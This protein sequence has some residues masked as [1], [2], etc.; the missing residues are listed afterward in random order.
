[1]K[2]LDRSDPNTFDAVIL[3][4][5]AA[6]LFCAGVSASRGLKVLVI[7]HCE[8]IAEKIRISGGGRCNFTNKNMDPQTP[9]KYFLG[10]NPQFCRS[11][12][13]K[14]TPDDFIELLNRYNVPF[15]EKHKGQLFCD[16]SAQN[17]IDVLISEAT[18]NKI[19]STEIR[20]PCKVIR[21]EHIKNAEPGFTDSNPNAFYSIT[22]D[23]SHVRCRS[24]VVATGGLSIPQ[25]GASDFGYSI[26]KQFNLSLVPTRPALV[27]LTF[28]GDTWAPYAHLSGLSL[29]VIIGTGQKKSR[30]EFAEDLL[31]THRGLSGPGVLQ[32]SSYWNPGDPVDV[33]LNPE[34]DL[35]DLFLQTK[36]TSR[37]LLVNEVST[38][39]PNRLA[40]AWIDQKTT[41]A[42]PINQISD[43]A[44]T[45]L[46]QN[47]Q[48]WEIQ[49][50]GTEGYKKAEV[51]AGGVNTKELSQQTME[52][53]QRGLYFIGEVV[54]ITGWLGGY[55]F[56][57]AWSSGF[58]CGQS[59]PQIE[60]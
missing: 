32:I 38:V 33:N 9:H 17:I 59:L 46:A 1:M 4:G 18:V 45:E 23:Q 16:R 29:P 44:L 43:Q 60:S 31:F 15:H 39:L 14:Y 47:L 26:A 24:L 3:G 37:R 19:G 7:D 27:P 5:G 54:D 42:N 56:Q 36:K 48:R 11:A 50:A 2:T 35:K 30:I 53:T 25:I 10:E 51:T 21:V 12:L 34:L 8:K 52:S 58:A 49:P 55:N 20:N 40:Q 13:S 22:T 28:A 57:W 41:L 6:G